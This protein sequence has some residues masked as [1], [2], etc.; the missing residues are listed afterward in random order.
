MLSANTL[1]FGV[2]GNKRF[3]KLI[4][5][6]RFLS[7]SH[8][9]WFRHRGVQGMAGCSG[10]WPGKGSWPLDSQHSAFS[11]A[12]KF[13][14]G[15]S[16]LQTQLLFRNSCSQ[17]LV[18][19]PFPLVVW[20]AGGGGLRFSHCNE[21][22]EGSRITGMFILIILFDILYDYPVCLQE[23]CSFQCAITVF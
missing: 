3:A 15:S 12:L 8:R 7:V 11:I 22:L 13:N 16:L 19:F 4:V 6:R 10:S 21:I 17:W 14:Q 18:N 20:W 9:C 23:Y 1:S 2:A 5:P